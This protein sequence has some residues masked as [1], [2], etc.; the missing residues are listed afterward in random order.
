[1][2][3]P[4]WSKVLRD[5]WGNKTRTVLVVLSIA[6]G[7]FAVGM[8]AASQVILARNMNDSFMAIGPSS[9]RLDTEVFDDDL[10]R[11]VRNMPEVRE[12]EGRYRL[13]V[14]IKAENGEWRS[15]QL[16]V[17]P[18]Y[19]DIQIN[20]IVAE[21]GA[22]PP[23]DHA[24]LIERAALGLLNARQ[25]DSVLL[26]TPSRKRRQVPIAGIAY[27]L[28]Q[29]PANFGVTAYGY[30]TFDTLEWLGETRAY[31]ELYVV[32]SENPYVRAECA[33]SG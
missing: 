20:K 3:N 23:P 10:V 4:C 15:L 21:S 18:D 32:A 14:R 9:A 1:V 30:A 27:D 16:F 29:W 31:N 5:L 12:A 25:G 33:R 26:E 22:W 24:I 28:H 8:M 17:V 13:D 2:R 19:D 6:V 11:A 7:V